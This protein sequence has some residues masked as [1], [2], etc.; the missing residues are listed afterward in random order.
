MSCMGNEL[1]CWTVTVEEISEGETAIGRGWRLNRVSL[2]CETHDGQCRF[3]NRYEVVTRC[4]RVTIRAIFWND[5]DAVA[6][7][8]QGISLCE[9]PDRSSTKRQERKERR[10]WREEKRKEGKKAGTYENLLMERMSLR[11]PPCVAE[12]AHAVIC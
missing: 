3:V 9:G 10:I 7:M 4:D 5:A 12:R 8:M 2:M 1:S 11:Y 6:H